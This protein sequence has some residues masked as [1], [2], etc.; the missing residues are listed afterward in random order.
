VC[1]ECNNCKNCGGCKK[2]INCNDCNS[3][4]ECEECYGF[5]INGECQ[6]LKL[7]YYGNFKSNNLNPFLTSISLLYKG[8]HDENYDIIDDCD[9]VQNIKDFKTFNNI[10]SP[11]DLIEYIIKVIN[12]FEHDSNNKLIQNFTYNIMYLQIKEVIKILSEYK[13]I[14]IS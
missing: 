12:L 4:E 5:K 9:I 1:K 7:L 14:N 8:L 2:C 11:M 3:C 10:K 6:T 13:I